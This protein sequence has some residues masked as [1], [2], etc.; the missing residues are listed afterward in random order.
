MYLHRM[1]GTAWLLPVLL[2]G[3]S[4]TMTSKLAGTP[5]SRS[6]AVVGERP[7][8]PSTGEAGDRPVAEA[9]EPEPRLNARRRISGRVIDEAGDPVPGATVRLA[10]GSDKGGQEIQ[11]TTDRSGAFSLNGL[12]P[13]STYVLIAESEDDKG[14]LHG[15]AEARTAET[16]IEIALV[17]DGKKPSAR[18]SARPAKVKPVSNRED[19]GDGGLDQPVKVNRE[20]V[21]P[22]SNSDEDALDPG[23]P[24]PIRGGRPQLAPPTGGV[25]WKNSRNAT[26]S[27]PRSEDAED[28]SASPDMPT[29]KRRAP[30]K[31]VPADADESSNPLPPAIDRD[32]WSGTDDPPPARPAPARSGS[33]GDLG[34]RSSRKAVESGEIVLVPDP[35]PEQEAKVE[36]AATVA[37]LEPAR[38]VDSASASMPDLDPVPAMPPVGADPVRV[39]AHEAPDP[40][41]SPPAGPAGPQDVAPPQPASQPAFASHDPANPPAEKPEDYNPFARLSPGGL[42][43]DQAVHNPPLVEAAPAAESPAPSAPSEPA[44]KKW[45][46]LASL[47][48]IA[49]AAAPAPAPKVT[50]T[51]ALFRRIRPAAEVAKA[52]SLAACLYDA[53]LRKINDFRLPDLE[54][55]P[56]RFQELNADYVLLDFWGTW[57]EPC[58]EAIPHLAELQAKYGPA[59]LKVVGVA[60]EQAPV[61]QRRAKVDEVSRKFGINYPILL[62]GMDGKSC[63][64]QQALQISAM[65]TM[66]LVDRKGQVVWRDT[67]STAASESRLDRVLAQRIGRDEPGWR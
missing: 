63:P 24:E 41:P 15:R 40:T 33:S 6:I 64:V 21:A 61:D 31:A 55:R 50:L 7:L 20:D 48:P 28:E 32:E 9:Q 42:P 26:A 36:S 19:L 65:P 43:V 58:L 17:A 4:S 5:E 29:P 27:R 23:P 3:C 35:D 52:P 11:G 39:A 2:A 47:A 13:G 53:R 54:G 38:A 14:P 60:C 45:S 49:P 57:C 51:S 67:G 66:I 34:S 44:R 59:R 12:R 1:L 56:V 62:S 22:G 8:P 37:K 46:E 18:R 25:G 30:K 10:D 16:G